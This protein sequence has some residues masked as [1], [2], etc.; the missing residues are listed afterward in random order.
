MGGPS[1]EHEISLKSGKAVYTA[2]KELGLKVIPVILPKDFDT[3]ADKLE[4]L[5]RELL[6]ESGINLVFNAL[7]GNFGEDGKLQKILEKLEI[8][9]TGSDSQASYLGMDKVASRKI[10]KK[11]GIPVPKYKILYKKSNFN[12][13]DFTF[14][15]VIKPAR[16]GSSIG[17]SIAEKKEDLAKALAI[18]FNYD[19]ELI[20][21]EYIVGKEITVAILEN[22]PLPVIQIVPQQR[23]YSYEAKYKDRN[24]RYLLPAP[25]NK[26]IQ[27]KAQEQA[28]KAHHS[29]GCSGF[30]RVDMILNKESVPVVLEVNTIPGLTSRSLLPKAAQAMDISFPELCLKILKSALDKKG[31]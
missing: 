31:C 12:E 28:I 17:V 4:Y 24:T 14:P 25:I 10:F 27:E 13:I 2:L 18:A 16:G 22:K 21:E 1:V 15:C 19:D 30:S 5:F 7:H 26:I 11:S 9:Y 20:V 23:F 3:L 8:P 29:L 6:E